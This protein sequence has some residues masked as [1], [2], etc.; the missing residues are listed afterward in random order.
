MVAFT[1]LML[2]EAVA[3]PTSTRDGVTRYRVR[4]RAEQ[5]DTPMTVTVTERGW[6]PRCG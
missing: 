4:T 2:P 5:R 1:D 6:I 3:F